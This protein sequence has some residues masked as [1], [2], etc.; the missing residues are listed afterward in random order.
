[1]Y[2]IR[3]MIKLFEESDLEE[4]EIV[5]KH[6]NAMIYM[7]KDGS[8]KIRTD[9]NTKA[10]KHDLKL[11]Y[12]AS[13]GKEAPPSMKKVEEVPPSTKND[14][15]K[16]LPVH[17]DSNLEKIV[18]PMVGTFYRKPSPEA[19]PYVEIGDPV[20]PTTVV[21]IVEAMKLFN[22][23]EAEVKGKIVQVLA[24]DGQIVEQGQPLFLVSPE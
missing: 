8:Q 23:I 7:K 3:E 11:A 21:C 5:L 16:T 6:S 10:K 20:E 12:V 18:S 24:E 15:V 2:E 9:E 19:E 14:K 4:M 22:E 13:N 1:M 17:I